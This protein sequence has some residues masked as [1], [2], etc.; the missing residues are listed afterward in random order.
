MADKS[1]AATKGKSTGLPI[2]RLLEMQPVDMFRRGM[3]RLLDDFFTGFS[4]RTFTDMMGD[5]ESF[6]F[7]PRIDMTEDEKAIHVNA[8]LPGL[9]EK[10]IDISLSDDALTIKGEKKEETERK[11]ETSYCSERSYGSFTRVLPIADVDIDKVD[12]T[13]TK[14]VLNITL[15]K[16]QE[17]KRSRR[18]IEIKHQ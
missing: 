9:D 15:P 12:A 5:L 16:L 14:G 11:D 8:E 6:T 1:V 2:R 7:N 4:L 3:D 13:F 18:K 17:T 10:D